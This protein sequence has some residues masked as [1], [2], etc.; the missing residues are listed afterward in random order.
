MQKNNL[1]QSIC[2]SVIVP[3]YNTEKYLRECIDAVINQT[4]KNFELI[5]VDD[6]ST[7]K[8]GEICDEYAEKYDF[9][10]VIHQ[11][12]NGVSA[13]RNAGIDAAQNEWIS[14][15]DSDDWIDPDMLEIIS[16]H[17][18]KEETD[19]YSFNMN[20]VDE[21]GKNGVA[22][23]FSTENKVTEFKDEK[24]KFNYFF[25]VVVP[26][27]V[28]N[29]VW[30]RIFR[31][32]IIT[33]NNLKFISRESVYAEDI[34][35]VFQYMLFTEKVGA[36]NKV[37]YNHRVRNNSL[38]NQFDKESVI[39]KLHTLAVCEYQKLCDAKMIYFC[40][41]FYK[42]YFLLMDG[43]IGYL[44]SANSIMS[45]IK[46]IRQLKANPLHKKWSKQ[47]RLMLL[48]DRKLL[49]K[50]TKKYLRKTLNSFRKS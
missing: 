17:I 48:K 25:S 36:V 30:E 26:G 39:L 31:K 8:S 1:K 45:T 34:L 5:L 42:L 14:F 49:W 32:K 43:Q 50:L 18:E 13:A 23:I 20:E 6:G 46:Q 28:G 35:F 41:E 10:K 19:L 29:T 47:I 21:Y 2:F 37:L 4:Y 22:R 12:N 16:E 44:Y 11:K 24:D 9:V 3:V 38:T 15:V 7:D 27:K 33:D 40:D